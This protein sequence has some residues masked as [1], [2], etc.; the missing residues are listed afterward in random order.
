M[1]AVHNERTKLTASLLNTAAG[2]SLT[3]GGIGPLVAVSYGVAGAPGFGAGTL[4]LI[5][6]V[7][8]VVAVGLHMLA[9]Y[10][11]GSLKP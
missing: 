10:V 1:S 8:I 4:S 7:W 3:A 9:R 5:I 2:F 6:L 11:L